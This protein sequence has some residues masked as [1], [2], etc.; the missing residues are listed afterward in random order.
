M[1]L[2]K[3]QQF[4]HLWVYFLGLVIERSVEVTNLELK[5]QEALVLKNIKTKN[6]FAAKQQRRKHNPMFGKS[7]N[8]QNS[9]KLKINFYKEIE[10]R[11]LTPR[12]GEYTQ[13]RKCEQWK[14]EMLLSRANHRAV[15]PPTTDSGVHENQ[16]REQDPTQESYRRSETFRKLRVSHQRYERL[17]GF[18]NARLRVNGLW[19]GRCYQ[20]S[21]TEIG[22][23]IPTP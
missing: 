4:Y 3:Y 23:R 19:C 8:Q 21:C 2:L 13:S 14:L 15:S 17:Y 9:L 20:E 1:Y 11:C 18:V 16:Q 5:R 7:F 22:T 10:P 12:I 6:V